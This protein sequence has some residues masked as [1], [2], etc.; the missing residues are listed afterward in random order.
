MNGDVQWEGGKVRKCEMENL[1]EGC[2][3]Q[4][5]DD[6]WVWVGERK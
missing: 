4:E 6:E 5:V 2:S 3:V 1:I